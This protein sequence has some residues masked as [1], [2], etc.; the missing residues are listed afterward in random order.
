[1]GR[2]GNWQLCPPRPRTQGRL[3]R[4]CLPDA[5]PVFLARFGPGPPPPAIIATMF[6]GLVET[7]GRIVEVRDEPPGVRLT[8]VAGDV[9]ADAPLTAPLTAPLGASVCV[10]GCC[11]SVVAVDGPRLSFQLG[12]ETLARTSLGGLASGA[13][14]NLERSLRLSDRLGG[15]LVTGHVDGVGRL[16]SRDESGDWVNCRF[17][18]PA[19]LLRQMA[20]KGSVAIDGVSLTL[21]DVQADWFSVALIPH[22]LA[23]TTIGALPVGGSVNLETDLIA[24]YVARWLE[25]AP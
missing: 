10:S 25:G 11:L 16:L 8:I 7:I 20:S 12:P 24:K 15:H 21:V 14:V 18:A 2:G 17:S 19:P 1:M 6:T 3:L 5:D 23:V 9:A 13:G 4:G 22:T